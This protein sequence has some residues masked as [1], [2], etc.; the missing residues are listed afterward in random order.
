MEA[1]LSAQPDTCLQGEPAQL[2]VLLA[3]W[4][5]QDTAA[6][7]ARCLGLNVSLPGSMVEGQLPW[8]CQGLWTRPLLLVLVLGVGRALWWGEQSWPFHDPSLSSAG[9]EGSLICRAAV[10]WELGQDRAVSCWPGPSWL[11]WQSLARS[12]PV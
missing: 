7:T 6:H 8:H 12:A 4:Q 10:S 1:Q 3:G 2:L 5:H 11:L 9:G